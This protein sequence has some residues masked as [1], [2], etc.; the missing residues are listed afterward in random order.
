MSSQLN[1]DADVYTSYVQVADFRTPEDG[2]FPFTYWL[3]MSYDYSDISASVVSLFVPANAKVLRVAHL[4]DEAFTGVTSIIVGDGSAT[5]G[6]IADAYGAGT[7]GTFITDLTST[8]A[9]VGKMYTTA[10]TID[11]T[12]GGTTSWTAG[13][14]KLFVEMLSYNED[15]EDT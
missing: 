11:V 15:L 12:L 3:N 2:M 6:W 5:N 1:G 7:A 13:S 10:D 14:G 9:A 4:I 8:Y